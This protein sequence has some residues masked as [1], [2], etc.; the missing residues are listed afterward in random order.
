MALTFIATLPRTARIAF[1]IIQ[2]GVREGLSSRAIERTIRD[3]GLQ[4]S[5][6]RGILPAMRA[7][8]ELEAQGTRVRFTNR[9]SAIN[10]TRLPPALTDIATQYSYRVRFTGIDE[11]GN[12]TER[13][14]QVAIDDPAWTRNMIEDKAW[15]LMLGGSDPLDF[16]PE[17]ATLVHGMQRARFGDFTQ[18]RGGFINTGG[19]DGE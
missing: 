2:R 16:V 3:A 9:Q 19:Q 12:Q 17:T 4:I 18:T 8:K 14:L 7:I 11:S 10:T 5:R 1:P 13:Y 6:S 15:T